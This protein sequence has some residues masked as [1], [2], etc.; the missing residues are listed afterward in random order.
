[1]ADA[2]KVLSDR[3]NVRLKE[4]GRKRVRVDE[5]HLWWMTPP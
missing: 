2:A 5:S 4:H 1:M 3:F